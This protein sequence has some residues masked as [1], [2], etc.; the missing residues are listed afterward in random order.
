MEDDRET[1]NIEDLLMVNNQQQISKKLKLIIL[2]SMIIAILILIILII[3][4]FLKVKNEKD[5][6]DKKE[7]TSIIINPTSKYTHCIIWLHGLDNYPENFR[8]LFTKEINIPHKNNTK[9]ILMR[10]PLMKMTYNGNNETSWFDIIRFPLNSSDTY[11]FEDAKKSSNIL[12]NYIHQEAKILGN[13]RN[14]FIG[15]HSQGACISLY[16]GYN[17]ENLIGGV[18]VC[19]GILFPQGEIFGDKQNLNVFLAH[20]DQDKA[21]PFEFHKQT[22]ERIINYKGVQKYYY[23]GHGHSIS[24][25]EKKDIEY[26]LNNTML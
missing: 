10:A 18:I 2:I 21:I 7:D 20:G 11:N 17:L 3:F 15:G 26:F 4:I 14:I 5:D 19:S 12:K 22:V 8:D 6:E 23:E 13:Y 1:G 24:D 16:S 9:I 25:Q